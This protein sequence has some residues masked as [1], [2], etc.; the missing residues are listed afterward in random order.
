MNLI[1]FSL[2][3]ATY[4]PDSDHLIVLI[5]P[6]PRWSTVS[7]PALVP[8]PIVPS[9][10]ETGAATPPVVLEVEL[11]PGLPPTVKTKLP[12]KPPERYDRS[13][14]YVG[15][16]AT[17]WTGR[18]KLRNTT[19]FVSVS[20]ATHTFPSI[21]EEAMCIAFDGVR[22]TGEGFAFLA[23]GDVLFVLGDDCPEEA[24]YSDATRPTA[25]PLTVDSGGGNGDID[26]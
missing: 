6:S 10:P 13:L 26:K 20:E 8:R 25:S 19:S 21:E 15:D 17:A 11:L 22:G 1:P 12:A 2:T 9:H 3:Q 7:F 16:N 18:P 24:L 23:P 4:L 14:L 5:A